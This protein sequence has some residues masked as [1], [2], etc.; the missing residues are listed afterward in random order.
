MEGRLV[1]DGRLRDLRVSTP[2]HRTAHKELVTMEEQDAR[3]P[4]LEPFRVEQVVRTGALE[5]ECGDRRV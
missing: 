2:P 5:E 3:V 4:A 1:T